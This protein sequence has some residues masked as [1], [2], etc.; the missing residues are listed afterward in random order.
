M[1]DE[2]RIPYAITV[3]FEGDNTM[4]AAVKVSLEKIL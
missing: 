2:K 1:Q 4:L 3:L